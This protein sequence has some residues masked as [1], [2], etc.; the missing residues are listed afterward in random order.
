MTAPHMVRL[1]T[2][3]LAILALQLSTGCGRS[4]VPGTPPTPE[5]TPPAKLKVTGIVQDVSVREVD[6]GNLTHQESQ[7]RF[8]VRLDGVD[9]SEQV[10]LEF[11]PADEP[12]APPVSTGR[13]ADLVAAP[14]ATYRIAMKYTAAETAVGIGA[15]EALTL[16]PA[17]RINVTVDIMFQ[18]GTLVTHISNRGKSVD[19]QTRLEVRPAD[20]AS[21]AP[22]IAR[23]GSGRSVRLPVGVY[24]VVAIWQN[25]DG[26]ARRLPLVAT[27]EARKVTTLTGDF[28]AA[29]ARVRFDIRSTPGQRDLS[30]T[31]TV[32]IR[33]KQGHPSPVDVAGG[34]AT[35]TWTIEAGTY[36]VEVTHADGPFVQIQKTQYN[37]RVPES[38]EPVRIPVAIPL[39][40]GTL[41]L[42]IEGASPC[43]VAI[44]LAGAAESTSHTVGLP[45]AIRLPAGD[46]DA[47]V[48]CGEPNAEPLVR[49][50]HGL[51]I[52]GGE[53]HRRR[54]AF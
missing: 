49:T 16:A 42:Q 29:L 54:I 18:T 45:N 14:P 25:A 5:P 19:N 7:A 24:A 31:S 20:A 37:L 34:A 39:A 26:V 48:R 8:R 12:D 51:A 28:D 9:V 22:P 6:G 33:N 40:V 36:D 27:I 23:T 2:L 41:D 11:L 13:G 43:R 15:I 30:A 35:T 47:V 52:T 46:W 17:Q 53:H 4:D 1:G 21:D 38:T 44:R 50:L 10:W 3:I 32:V